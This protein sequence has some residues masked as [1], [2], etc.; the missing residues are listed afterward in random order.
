MGIKQDTEDSLNDFVFTKIDGQPTGE[1]LN[2]LTKECTNAVSSISTTNVGGQHGHT[3]MV[4]PTAEYVSFS[5]NAER[6]IT[7]TNPG[8]YPDIVNPDIVV[9]E[10]QS[11]EHKADMQNMKLTMEYRISFARPS[12]VQLIR[13]GSPSLKVK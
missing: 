3:G 13:N 10:R 9:R 8:L 11:A 4:I 7:L 1:D 6:F 12:F 5:Q 2:Q